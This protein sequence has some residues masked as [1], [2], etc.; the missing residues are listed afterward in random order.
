MIS[1]LSTEV[2]ALDVRAVAKSGWVC[3]SPEVVALPWILIF[4]AANAH[5]QLGVT[6]LRKLSWQD[7]I[8]EELGYSAGSTAKTDELKRLDSLRIFSQIRRRDI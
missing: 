5:Q 2:F 1:A 3:E 4:A 7:S 6:D 8:R